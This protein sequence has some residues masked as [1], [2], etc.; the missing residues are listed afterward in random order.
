M[1]TIFLDPADKSPLY[2]QIARRLEEAILSGQLRPGDKLPTVR[3]LARALSAAGGTVKR[4]YEELCRRGLLEMTQGKGTFVARPFSPDSRKEQAMSAIDAMLDQM[5]SLSFSQREIQIFLDL[6]LRE[7]MREPGLRLAAIDC[8]PE[9][10][11]MLT[12]QLYGFAD[13]S[14]YPLLLDDALENPGQLAGEVDLAVTTRRHMDQLTPLLKGKLPLAGLCLR[15]A[16]TSLMALARLQPGLRLGI[17]AQSQSF[18]R[19]ARELCLRCCPGAAVQGV[20]LSEGAGA[21]DWCDGLV[22]PLSFEQSWP[23]AALE[24]ISAFAAARP[25]VRLELEPD[26]GSLHSL[27]LQLRQ[28]AR[29][30]R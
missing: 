10:L 19:Y 11:W 25:L 22:A 28:I 21:L 24:R 9:G 29:N 5:E 3:E 2:Q 14:V 12:H 16:D 4:A 17:L 23:A 20:F 13:W 7:R 18:F 1:P 6:K 8:C 27:E 26:S 15:A 30:R